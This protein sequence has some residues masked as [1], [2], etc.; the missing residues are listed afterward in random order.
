MQQ[1]SYD[2]RT[3]VHA[4]KTDSHAASIESWLSPADPSTNVNKARKS[5]HIGTGTWFLNSD[6]FAEWKLGSRRHLWLY[7]TPGC[8][9][10]V[11]S[12][13]ILDHLDGIEDFITLTFFFDFTDTRKQNLD[14]MLRSLVFQLYSS[15]PESRQHLDGLFA[16][17]KDGERQKQPG[18]DSLSICLTDM[19]KAHGKLRILLD[20]LDECSERR[21]LLKW[22]ESISALAYVQLIATGRPEDEFERTLRGSVGKENCLPLNKGFVNADIHSY[23]TARLE[24]G[25]E[26]KRWAASWDVLEE[27]KVTIS[28]KADGM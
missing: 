26:F 5:R 8:G 2:I 28:T 23:V 1:V 13:T 19:M 12:A 3:D 15:G 4:M 11:L 6:P 21:E 20:A 7:G 9:K 24:Q 10:T 25:Q 14:D 27:I 17:H 16:S 18:T 22:M